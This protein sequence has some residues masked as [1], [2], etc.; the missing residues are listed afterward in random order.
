MSNLTFTGVSHLELYVSD[1][2]ASVAWYGSA[3]ALFPRPHQPEQVR[4]FSHKTQAFALCFDLVAPPT[5]TVTSATLRW[6]WTACRT[7][8][9]GPSIWTKLGCS[10]RASRKGQQVTP[11]IWWTP[12]DTTSSSRTNPESASSGGPM[13]DA[14]LEHIHR[15]Q[16][17]ASESD[18]LLSRGVAF[19]LSQRDRDRVA[20]RRI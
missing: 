13:G 2:E 18:L 17:P 7:W 14:N 19:L 15:R 12:T 16:R 20:T 1:L 3:V 4:V 6:G 9:P 5:L 10:T 11:S 8:R